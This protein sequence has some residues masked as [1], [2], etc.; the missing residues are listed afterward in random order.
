LSKYYPK[1]KR[2]TLIIKKKPY[3][4]IVFPFDKDTLNLVKSLPNRKFYKINKENYWLAPL[5][6]HTINNLHTWGFQLDSRLKKWREKQQEIKPAI[7]LNE[8]DVPGFN[9]ILR[10]Y[11]KKSISFIQKNGGR[12]LL[13][14]VT[15]LG[16]TL[17][18]IAWINITT[19]INKC[20]IICPS[21]V[22]VNWARELIKWLDNPTIYI[23]E[24]F[25][26][27][28]ANMEQFLYH[29]GNDEKIFYICNYKIFA[30]K[31]KTKGKNKIE[32]LKTG[33]ADY[34]DNLDVLVGDESHYFSNHSANRTKTIKRIAKK[35]KYFIGLTATPVEN[36]PKDL[37]T[38][39]NIINQSIFPNFFLFAK[40]YCNAQLTRYGWNFDGASNLEELNSILTE[41]IMVRFLK[42]EVEKDLPSINKVVIPI[43]IDNRTIYREILNSEGN[44]FEKLKQCAVNG[45]MN[46]AID[47]INDFLLSGNKLV[48]FAHHRKIVSQLNKKYG[49]I[50]VK[51]DGSTTN[52]QEVIDKFIEDDKIKLFIANI[53][54][55]STGIN[56]LHDV[57]NNALFLELVYNPMLLEQAEGRLLRIGQDKS[58]NIFY[59]LGAN[60]IEEEIMEVLDNKKTIIDKTIDGKET[61]GKDLFLEL[62]K[63]YS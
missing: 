19:D 38:P 47:W 51:L 17:T 56:G 23:L 10:P 49:A 40:R 39:C 61:E 18:T 58:V 3:V 42:N 48:V 36:R 28:G 37:F 27:N 34:L 32:L 12:S 16:K 31:F 62:K 29:Q 54:S 52:R 55:G 43:E 60:T 1:I 5:N 46:N 50:S 9:D 8:A 44:R 26:K 45:K 22:K 21:S 24:G 4:K 6:K 11:Q 15:G 20:G 63:K 41:S 7:K 33:W 13:C 35:I 59:L 25:P 14:L 57:C 2:A 53:K 30:N